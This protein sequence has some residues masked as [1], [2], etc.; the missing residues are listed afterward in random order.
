MRDSLAL[1]W[2]S[3]RKSYDAG[4]GRRTVEVSRF[5]S[6]EELRADITECRRCPR[7]VRYR[8]AVARR[9]V[10]RFRDWTYWG[11]PV[12]G[13]GDRGARLLVIGL[14]P[15]AHGGNRTGRVFTGD[16][17]GDWLHR[18]LHRA[19]FASQPT[20]TRRDDGLRLDGCYV[21]ASV[22][23]APPGN[24]PSRGEFA[25]CAP[26]LERE[27]ELLPGV[28]AVVALG[29][30]AWN[31]FLHAWVA[32]GNENP[33]PKPRFGHGA[34]VP[35]GRVV[36]FGS[37]HPSQRNTRT[38]RLTESMFDAVFRSARK[39]LGVSGDG[40]GESPGRALVD[41]QQRI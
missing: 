9:K 8:E 27:I 18:A 13:F 28:R 26:F 11:R 35:L 22:R 38:G 31:S 25:R 24:R 39:R 4:S 37:Y 15:A 33:R 40:R 7:L 34:V 23:C 21:T 29:E 19:G 32:L 20:S 2:A 1:D 12:P 30:A 36:L 3:N 17:S 6:L 41:P 14:A 10:A 5:R 16:A